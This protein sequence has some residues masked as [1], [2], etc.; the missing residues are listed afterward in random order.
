MPFYFYDQFMKHNELY[1]DIETMMDIENFETD[2]DIQEK[3]LKKLRKKIKKAETPAWIITALEEMHAAFPEGTSLRYRSSTNNEDLPNF[4]GAGLYD[5]KTQDP[6]ETK[7]DGIDKSI[8]GVWASLWN[9]RAFVERDFHRVDHLAAAMGV[10]VHPNYSDEKA[11]GVAVSFDPI[12]GGDGTYYVNTQVGEDLVTNPEAHSVPE[13]LLLDEDGEYTVLV[14]SNQAGPG[15]LL[16]SDAQIGQLR[17]R[18][19]KIHE[20]FAGLYGIGPGEQFA[21]D[22]E[23]KITS[24]NVLAIKQAR[25]WVFNTA[26]ATQPPEPHSTDA[27]LS[28]LEL[29][30]VTL[31]PAFAATTTAYTAQVAN[32]VTETT[33]TPAVNDGGATYAIKLDGVTDADG[34][35]P[36]SVGENVVTIEVTAED[37]ETTHTYTVTVTRAAPPLSADA[38]LSS[39]TLSGLTL[40]FDPATSAYT[41]SVANDMERT[42]VTATTS[43]ANATYLVQLDGADDADG[44]M[45][46]AVGTN[47]IS[48]VVTAEDGETTRTYTVAVTR[49]APPLS[50]ATLSELTLSGVTLAFDPANTGYAVSVVHDLAETAVTPTTNDDEATYAIKLDGV[51]DAD[52]VIPLSVGENVEVSIVVTAEDGE[53]T[54]TYTVTV[55]RAAV[56]PATPDRPAGQLTG[57]GAVS[58]DWNDVPTATSYDVRVWQVD[59]HTEL[60]ADASVNGISIAFNGSGATVSGLPTDYEW[61]FFE[62]RAVNDAGA[63]GWSPNNAIEVPNRRA[64]PRAGSAGPTRRAV[65][66]GGGGVAG[67]ERRAN[68][69]LVHRVGVAGRRLDRPVR[70]RQRAGRQHR[71]QRLQ[72]TVSG[73][74]TDYEWYYFVVR[75]VNGWWHLRLVGLQRHP[76]PIGQ[77]GYPTDDCTFLWPRSDNREDVDP[78][79]LKVCNYGSID[80][81]GDGNCRRQPLF[82]GREADDEPTALSYHAFNLDGTAVG[83][84]KPSCYGQSQAGSSG[85]AGTGGIGAIEAV[86]DVRQVMGRNAGTGVG[87]HHLDGIDDSM[88]RHRHSAAPRRMSD[89]V[90]QQVADSLGDAGRIQVHRRQC[91]LHLKAEGHPSGLGAGTHCFESGLQHFPHLRRGQLQFQLAGVGLGQQTQVLDQPRQ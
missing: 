39:L 32:D 5:S 53:T 57:E 59:A 54:R 55:T 90:L 41:A 52:G 64:N 15:E 42:T 19:E 47:A 85:A 4:S 60:S 12:R 65:D 72:A 7:E 26:S 8:K 33:V 16:M 77:P 83:L 46:L 71:L 69:N 81:G 74:P 43:D 18:L 23:F 51:A 87:H 44:T 24:E 68:G 37:G 30:G 34:V 3:E 9:F 36:L 20:H 31:S 88:G 75:A 50:D 89:G 56:P 21:M 10:L 86:E 22:I 91:G 17:K 61:Y 13:E 28:G 40:A 66:R 11:N 73:L 38:T 27:T 2:F 63:S 45:A 1:D 70:R 79:R 14:R 84:D 67:L 49:A 76:G 78:I 29:G 80:I 48:I 58:L 82:A 6:E 35:I 25:P 62:V